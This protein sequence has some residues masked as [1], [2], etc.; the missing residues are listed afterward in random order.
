[1]RSEWQV[2]TDDSG[3]QGGCGGSWEASEQGRDSPDSGFHRVPL[4][5]VAGLGRRLG[6]GSDDRQ[7]LEAE[8]TAS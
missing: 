6:E 7:T 2:P 1:M 5:V 3:P 8:L 4:L